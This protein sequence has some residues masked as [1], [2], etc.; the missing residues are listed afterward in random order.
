MIEFPD[1]VKELLE[2]YLR[3]PESAT[4]SPLDFARFA[5]GRSYKRPPHLKLL[6][7]KLLEAAEGNKRLMVLMPPR[8]GKSW[9][10]SR[11]FPAWYV[12]THPDHRVMLASYEATLAEK[13]GREARDLIIE[14]G[15]LFGVQ[16]NKDA[17]SAS[18][19]DVAGHDGGMYAV[20]AGGP[21]TG[22]GANVFIIDDP[23]K[24]SEEANSQIQREKIWNWFQGVVMT[25]LEPNASII[26]V[27]TRWH[28]DDVAGRLLAAHADEWEVLS[29][30]ALA[31]DTD[32]LGRRAGEALWSERFNVQDLEKIREQ[33]GSYV[34]TSL[35]QQSP[36]PAGGHIVQR[37]WFRYW[38]PRDKILPALSVLNGD[39]ERISHSPVSLPEQ[40]DEVIQSWDLSFKESA[41]SDYVVGQTWGLVGADRYLLDQVRSRMD[42][43]KTV[44]A[45]K[46]MT[47]K[48]PQANRKF[49]EAKANGE[50]LL[51]SLR[52][53]ISGFIAVNPTEDKVSRVHA[54]SAMIESGNVYLPHPHHAP[55]V[56]GFINECVSFPSGKFDDQVDCLSQA[57]SQT[58]RRRKILYAF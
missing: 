4:L 58:L 47:A 37:S 51:S 10:V 21:I 5:I 7:E 27:M 41:T 2:A 14:H 54:V 19:W 22:K 26:L 38:Q 33:V 15:P 8:H 25:R 17:Q 11:F 57:L 35:Y 29:L 1:N 48:W 44:A 32:A 6:N 16:L 28:Q 56:D 13:W 12:G 20:G 45:I 43:P 39:G 3:R 24:G 34:W 18:R 50:A 40:F 52:H 55:W 36:V 53:E 30:P 49:I 23:L 42:F 46:A 9:L 31:E